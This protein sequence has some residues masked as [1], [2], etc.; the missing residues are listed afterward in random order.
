[1]ESPLSKDLER[2]A[3]PQLDFSEPGEPY[4]L[5]W[6]AAEVDQMLRERDRGF[7]NNLIWNERMLTFACLGSA[8]VSR[9]VR[10]ITLGL[11]ADDQ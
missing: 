11:P 6:D 5:D 7:R 8:R 2:K 9:S 4:P 1:M 3:P 10:V